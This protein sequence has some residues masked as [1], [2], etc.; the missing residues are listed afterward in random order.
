MARSDHSTALARSASAKTRLA[1]L[2]P[3]SKLTRLRVGA[4]AARMARPVADSPVKVTRS[5]PGSSV[6]AWPASP[7]PEPLDDVERPRRQAGLAGQQAEAV[8]GRRR[9]LGRLEHDRVAEG[10]G[11]GDL[12]AGQHER[13][14]PGRDGRGHPDRLV[15]GVD[16]VAGRRGQRLVGG[17]GGVVGEEAEVQGRPVGVVV[18]GLADRLAHVGRV[19]PAEGGRPRPRSGR[20]AGAGPPRARPG[21]SAARARRRRRAGRRPRPPPRPPPTRGPPGPRPPRWPG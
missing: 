4:P 1:P 16:V 5:T 8:A 10:Q 21:P 19:Q 11:G 13:E 14:V 17:Q 12:P 9:L 18:A 20:P 7:G 15:P 3:S 2:P 6:R